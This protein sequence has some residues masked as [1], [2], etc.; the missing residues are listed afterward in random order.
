MAD[1]TER[2]PHRQIV[3][4]SDLQAGS[5][6]ESLQA[7]QW[8]AS[9]RVLVRQISPEPTTNASLQILEPTEASGQERV[10]RVRVTNDAASRRQDFEVQWD[11]GEETERVAAPVHV[12][13]PPGETRVVRMPAPPAAAACRKPLADRR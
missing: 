11:T 10:M 13:V 12:S 7:Y 9:V 3:V 6:I 8:P 1:G 5:Q 4:I 2:E